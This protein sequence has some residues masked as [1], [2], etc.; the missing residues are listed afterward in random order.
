M[1]DRMTESFEPYR[2][3]SSYELDYED[4]PERGSPGRVLWGRVAILG[5]ALLIAFFIGRATGGGDGVSQARFDAVAAERDDLAD[6]VDAL[7]DDLDAATQATPPPA[8]ASPATGAAEEETE[9]TDP[10]NETEGGETY[11][12]KSG[13]T[14]AEIALFYYGDASLDDLIAEAN[15]IA[16]PEA[17]V[18]GTEITIPPEPE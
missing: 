18:V 17:L 2:P 5:L 10:E 1:G 16:D 8:S 6:E 13:D 9:A 14:L 3:E 7:R 11:V 4:E 15:D 12:I